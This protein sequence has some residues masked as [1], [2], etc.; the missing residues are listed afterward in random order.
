MKKNHSRNSFM[1][2]LVPPSPSKLSKCRFLRMRT[3][4]LC[5]QV[6]TFFHFNFIFSTSDKYLKKKPHM[7][8]FT[9]HFTVLNTNSIYKLTPPPYQSIKSEYKSLGV[10]TE[11]FFTHSHHFYTCFFSTGDKYESI[12]DTNYIHSIQI[13]VYKCNI[14][15]FHCHRCPARPGSSVSGV[16][17]SGV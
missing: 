2:I 5:T 10:W 15:T 7:Q 8:F 11:T 6:N 9:T 16:Q 12:Y 3:R 13:T 4:T 14:V 17:V 1:K